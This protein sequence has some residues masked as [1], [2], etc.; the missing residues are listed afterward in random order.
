VSYTRTSTSQLHLAV[1]HEKRHLFLM[2]D[3]IFLFFFCYICK[4]LKSHFPQPGLRYPHCPAETLL[5]F[6]KS[7]LFVKQG[8]ITVLN[9]VLHYPS[10][11]VLSEIIIHLGSLEA[12]RSARPVGKSDQIL[13]C[14][15]LLCLMV[16]ASNTI[17]VH[18]HKII[19]CKCTD[20]IES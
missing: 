13:F 16:I 5:Y 19:E 8:G 17:C 14:H 12:R 11:F 15:E 18:L 20:T 7:P 2:F 4:M 9:D 10:K 6:Q 1:F 3:F